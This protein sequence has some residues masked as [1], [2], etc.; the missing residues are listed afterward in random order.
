MQRQNA[1]AERRRSRFGGHDAERNHHYDCE[2]ANAGAEEPESDR[3]AASNR[4]PLASWSGFDMVRVLRRDREAHC[5]PGVAD[6][7][8][9]VGALVAAL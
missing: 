6:S 1:K 3:H 8:P 2:H 7:D 5:V 9:G 4:S